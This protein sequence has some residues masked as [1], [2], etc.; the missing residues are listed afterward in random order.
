MKCG[1]LALF[2]LCTMNYMYTMEKIDKLEKIDTLVLQAYIAEKGIEHIQKQ[3]AD[4][5]EIALVDTVEVTAEVSYHV[6]IIMTSGRLS[7]DLSHLSVEKQKLYKE[8]NTFFKLYFSYPI[9][10]KT[11]FTGYMSVNEST[12]FNMFK[13]TFTQKHLNQLLS[14]QQQ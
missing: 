3:F 13:T 9:T 2:L 6:P 7:F 10:E 4:I 11:D 1:F 5:S 8:M 14:E 12:G